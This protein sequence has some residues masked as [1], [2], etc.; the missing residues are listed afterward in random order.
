MNKDEMIAK[1]LQEVFEVLAET[2]E[3]F[4]DQAQIEPKLLRGTTEL[5]QTIDLD[6]L[7]ESGTKL[8]FNVL[9]LINT[10][11]IS[12][13]GLANSFGKLSDV[14]CE[15]SDMLDGDEETSEYETRSDAMRALAQNGLA[16]GYSIDEI[17]EFFKE[18]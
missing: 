6:E 17:K 5:L 1:K 2:M 16:T 3:T 18:I 4:A 11:M 9:T 10:I 15:F 12:R 7:N 13:I 8:Y 14:V